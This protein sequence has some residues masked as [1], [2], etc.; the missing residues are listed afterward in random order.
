MA[1]M[2]NDIN[3]EVINIASGIPVTIRKVIETVKVLIGQGE[4]LFG[5]IPYRP[6]ENMELYADISKANNVLNWKPEITLEDGILR[7]IDSYS[8]AN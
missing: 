7:T 2:Q 6:K 4:P 8:N 3:G 5:Q 1:L